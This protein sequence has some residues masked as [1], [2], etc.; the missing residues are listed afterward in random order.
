MRHRVRTTAFGAGFLFTGRG[1][2]RAGTGTGPKR[3]PCTNIGKFEG[4]LP[5]GNPGE[6]V[7]AVVASQ[8]FGR[9]FFDAFFKDHPFRN[10]PVFNQLSHPGACAWV[11][12]VVEDGHASTLH[13]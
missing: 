5:A 13:G 10:Q 1:E 11:V 2:G 7:D 4:V 6:E 12:V 3:S 8:L 9:D